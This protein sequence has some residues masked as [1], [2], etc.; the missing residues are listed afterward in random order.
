M[1]TRARDGPVRKLLILMIIVT[2]L[3]DA[4]RKIQWVCR[5]KN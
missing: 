2:Q 3:I 4:M 5:K 1:R